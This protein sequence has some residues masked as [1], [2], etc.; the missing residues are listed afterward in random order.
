[1][2]RI[3]SVT[4]AN[5]GRSFERPAWLIERRKRQGWENYCTRECSHEARSG[6]RRSEWIELVCANPD[7]PREGGKF[8]VPP[9][10]AAKRRTCS[11]SCAG[12]VGG[13]RR[14]KGHDGRFVSN[15]GY[16]FVYVKPADRPSWSRKRSYYQEH[17]VVMAQVLDRWPEPH[18][19]VHH[20]NGDKTDN[21]PENLQ[22][23]SG[24]HG[25]GDI[26]YCADCGSRNIEYESL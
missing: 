25:K 24:R 17:R 5:C 11:L 21:R 3:L 22:L 6:G 26:P 13:K 14:L 9:Y 8:E 7:C 12:K 1:M 15:E 2:P 18:E 20:I 4:C 16:I 23:R 19:T 10:L